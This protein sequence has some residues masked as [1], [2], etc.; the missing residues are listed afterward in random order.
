M[1]GLGTKA[2]EYEADL[3]AL[4]LHHVASMR[5]GHEGPGIRRHACL[6]RHVRHASMRPGHEGPGI[7][8]ARKSRIRELNS[9]FP[10]AVPSTGRPDRR[11]GP[12]RQSYD[13]KQQSKS[14]SLRSRERC[15]RFRRRRSARERIAAY[16][17]SGQIT[18]ARRSIGANVLAEAF[19]RHHADNEIQRVAASGHIPAW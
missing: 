15:R 6:H 11:S 19:D 16:R 12:F 2:R 3:L 18:T 8:P 13:I 5:P 1:G 9:P 4:R 7:L 10:R 14:N 17:E